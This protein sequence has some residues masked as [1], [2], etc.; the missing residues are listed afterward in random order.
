MPHN[1]HVAML[2]LLSFTGLV[3]LNRYSRLIIY[4]N[5]YMSVLYLGMMT[6]EYLYYVPQR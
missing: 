3:Q 4:D 6:N 2:I 5:V 1:A